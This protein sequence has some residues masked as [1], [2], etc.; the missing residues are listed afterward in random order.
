[1]NFLALSSH[2]RERGPESVR[3]S[4]V[5]EEFPTSERENQEKDITDYG[6]PNADPGELLA[7]EGFRSEAYHVLRR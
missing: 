2:Y 6:H 1:M 3:Q 7:G 5:A 4:Y